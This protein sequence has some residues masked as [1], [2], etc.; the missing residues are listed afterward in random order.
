[1]QLWYLQLSLYAATVG[2]HVRVCYV[3]SGVVV[4]VMV[5]IGL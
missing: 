4:G 1:M 5:L 2:L 3:P